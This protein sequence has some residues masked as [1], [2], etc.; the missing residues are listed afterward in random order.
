MRIIDPDRRKDYYDV[1]MRAG[2]DKDFVYLRKY[3][4][5][6]AKDPFKPAPVGQNSGYPYGRGFT[7]GFCGRFY[8]CVEFDAGPSYKPT[9]IHCYN[10]EQVDA[11]VKQYHNERAWEEYVSG[12]ISSSH[13][14][15]FYQPPSL[16]RR[17]FEQYFAEFAKDASPAWQASL[18]QEHQAPILVFRKQTQWKP[19]PNLLVNPLLKNYSFQRVM[20]AFTA[21]QEISMFLGGMAKPDKPIPHVSDKDMLQA[22]GFD[23]KW[24]FRREPGKK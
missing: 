7:L 3:E 19:E 21:Y 15:Y 24:S 4:E 20:D 9:P 17:K 14:S 1:G 5:K 23:K 16:I 10:I 6:H 2:F 18:F 11:F 22:K 8:A 13:R 12:K